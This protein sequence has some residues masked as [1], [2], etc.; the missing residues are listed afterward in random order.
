LGY[1]GAHR[2]VIVKEMS[3][4]GEH[5]VS[6]PTIMRVAFGLGLELGLYLNLTDD[7]LK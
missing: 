4:D 1:A 2:E 7:V 3:S 6:R 5:C